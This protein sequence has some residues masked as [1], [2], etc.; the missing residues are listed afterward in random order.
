MPK[1]EAVTVE[2]CPALDNRLVR[3]YKAQQHVKMI[4]EEIRQVQTQLILQHAPIKVGDRL[5]SNGH[6]NAG[7]TFVVETVTCEVCE[8]RYMQTKDPVLVLRARGPIVLQSGAISGSRRGE[9]QCEPYP[10]ETP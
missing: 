9:H 3:I 4:Q 8:N 10:F 5:E 6:R 1:S 2:K 7:K